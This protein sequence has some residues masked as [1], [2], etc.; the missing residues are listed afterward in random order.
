MSSSPLKW[1]ARATCRLPVPVMKLLSGKPHEIEGKRLDPVVQF[2]VRHFA[3]PPGTLDS[4]E[5]TRAGFDLQGDWLTHPPAPGVRIEPWLVQGPAG[6]IRCEIHRPAALPRANAPVL[7][8]YHG[9]GHVAGSLESHRE[10]CRQ[11]AHEGQCAVVAV[12]YRLAPEH[13]F[14]VGIRDCLAAF[15]AV[16]VE[17]DTL[18]FDRRR[19]AVG[20][21]SA[22]GNAAAV[23][24][25]QRSNAPFPPRVQMLWVPWLDMSKQSRSYQLF[26][27]GF[28]L[29]KAKMEWYTDLYLSK[30]EDALDPLA[31]PLLGDVQGVCPAV[32]LIAGFD[33]LRDEGLAYGAKLKSAGIPTHVKV[34]EGLVHPFINVAGFVPAAN[35]AFTEAMRLLR[36]RL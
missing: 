32:L 26:A 8:F 34:F 22:G 29:E 20:G 4:V 24:A 35:A 13:R 17:A 18:G 10:V 36:E 27:E 21:D 12:D 23:V 19:V 6:P 15:D 33:P 31:S 7:V 2:M 9:G 3:D 25:Q 11:L 16:V 1:V 5:K 28:F 30:P 14:P